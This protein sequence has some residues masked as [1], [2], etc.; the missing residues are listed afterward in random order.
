MRFFKKSRYSKKPHRG[1]EHLRI[2]FYSKKPRRWI[3]GGTAA[4]LVLA[5]VGTL[6]LLPVGTR[7]GLNYAWS[8]QQIFLSEKLTHFLSRHFQTRRL[9]Q[10]VTQGALNNQEKI[11]KIFE[12]VTEN[13]RTPPRGFPIVDDHP[14]HILIRGYGAPD[15]RT[16]AFAL[17]ASYSG[18]PSEAVFLGAEGTDRPIVVALVRVGHKTVLVDVQHQFLFR[19][20]EGELADWKELAQNPKLV[21]AVAKGRQIDGVAYERFYQNLDQLEPSFVRMELQ[22]PWPRLK[23][24]IGKLAA[25]LRRSQEDWKR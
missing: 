10:K 25:A 6:A 18:F 15:Q 4:V 13:V 20:E 9:A 11:A 7:S 2:K 23:N 3:Q 19:N 24:K 14:L 17:L 8:T 12:W 21:A 22:K 5:G 1:T 16:E